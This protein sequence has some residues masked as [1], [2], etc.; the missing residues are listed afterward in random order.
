M[1][2]MKMMLEESE[3]TIIWELFKNKF[4]AKYF[5][6]SVKYAKEVELL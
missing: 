3:G 2:Y 1:E 4:Y 6:D 5:L